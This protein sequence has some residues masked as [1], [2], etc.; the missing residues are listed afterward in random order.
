MDILPAAERVP[1]QNIE[2][3]QA[4]L[5]AVLSNNAALEKVAEFLKPEYFAS[6][7]HAKIYETALRLFGRGHIANP[8]TLKEAL[9]A[10]SQLEEVGGIRYL[11]EL[12]RSSATIINAEDYARLIADRYF[13]RQLVAL[14]YDITNDAYAV[15][16][17]NDA[18]HQIA[19]AEQKLYNLS[20]QGDVEGGPQ[21]L[22]KPLNK[23]MQA[24]S[25]AMQNPDGISGLTTGL[26]DLDKVMGGFHDSDL[27]ILAGRPAMGKTALATNIAFNAAVHLAEQAAKGG[28]RKGVAFFSLEMSADQ[29]AGRILAT[30][31]QISAHNLRNGKVRQEEFTRLAECAAQLGKLPLYVDET[32]ALTV[33]KI[34]SRARRLK[35]D[36]NKGLGLIVIDYLQL[37]DDKDTLHKENRVQSLSEVTRNLKMMAKDLSVPVL[38]LSQLSRQVESRDDKRPLLSDLRESGSIEQDA[39]VVMFIF[40]EFYYLENEEPKQHANET[41]IKFQ[42]RLNKIEDKKRQV[43]KKAELI[44]GKQ[45]HGPTA[46]IPLFFEKEYTRFS[47]WAETTADYDNVL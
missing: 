29:L 13:R 12:V 21:E 20:T 26:R 6:P 3:E 32:P 37:I 28:E 44:I 33:A 43:E 19:V 24:T 38:V 16:V 41:D 5:G 34:R 23:V 7:A 2:A 46:T 11:T 10:D 31:A 25:D 18:M 35:T 47:N 22:D 30:E 27:I 40:R 1:P 42:E 9:S 8:V 36:K 39:D 15:S 14:G 4:L 17:D 45:R